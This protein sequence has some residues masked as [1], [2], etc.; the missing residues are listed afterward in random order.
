MSNHFINVEIGFFISGLAGIFAKSVN[1][2]RLVITHFSQRYYPVD[3]SVPEESV[4]ALID[5]AIETFKSN[6][7]ITAEGLTIVKV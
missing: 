6:N 5:Q 7:V 4:T 3:H 2:K 1:A